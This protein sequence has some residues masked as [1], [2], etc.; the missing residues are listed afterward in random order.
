MGH[1]K[2]YNQRPVCEGLHLLELYIHFLIKVFH[3]VVFQIN[4]YCLFIFPNFPSSSLSSQ[5]FLQNI[6]ANQMLSSPQS[7]WPEIITVNILVSIVFSVHYSKLPYFLT[8]RSM[9]FI[10]KFLQPPELPRELAWFIS[11]TNLMLPFFTCKAEVMI[12]PMPRV[13]QKGY[14]VICCQCAKHAGIPR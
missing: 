13:S 12:A 9:T 11:E 2:W 4:P 8:I 5:V 1:P 7:P 14:Q 6:N 10:N 3:G